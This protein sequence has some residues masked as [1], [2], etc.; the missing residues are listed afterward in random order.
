[1]HKILPFVTLLFLAVFAVAQTKPIQEPP[2]KFENSN[3]KD[4]KSDAPKAKDSKAKWK[5]PR[6]VF[7]KPEKA[8]KDSEAPKSIDEQIKDADRSDLEE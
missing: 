6:K 8:Q 4:K 2:L 7:P 3:S 5:A 1:M